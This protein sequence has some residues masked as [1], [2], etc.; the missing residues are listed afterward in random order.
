MFAHFN[1]PFDA[2]Q[3]M[4]CAMEQAFNRDWRGRSTTSRGSFPLVKVFQQ[5]DDLVVVA[6]MPG[7]N[8]EH[9]DIT[10][11]H[12]KLRIAGER[13]IDYG[14]KISVHR[15]ERVAGKFERSFT[16]PLEIDA[17][18]VR[19]EFNNGLLVL[20]LPRAEKDRPKQIEIN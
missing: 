15:R 16:L 7:V 13:R 9:L 18:N 20:H 14:D 11:Q 19:A 1:H 2:L 8:K 5:N 6:E 3:Q 12:N 10:I 4:Q 17:A